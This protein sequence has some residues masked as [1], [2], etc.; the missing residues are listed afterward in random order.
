MKG[1]RSLGVY[2]NSWILD[3]FDSDKQRLTERKLFQDPVTQWRR[4]RQRW[5]NFVLPF[6]YP[7]N[8]LIF[9]SLVSFYHCRSFGFF[10]RRFWHQNAFRWNSTAVCPHKSNI[11]RPVF[12]LCS[13][14]LKKRS[15]E[16][17]LL[18]IALRQKKSLF[19]KHWNETIDPKN[20]WT[21]TSDIG[22]EAIRNV[23]DK[24]NWLILD[25]LLKVNT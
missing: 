18:S 11:E 22:P 14:N 23:N 9:T 2:R 1:T 10:W 5:V 15:D 8:Y 25:W 24:W 3:R 16:K 6:H 20:S 19:G 17:T 13:N 12:K 4:E 7:V 21:S